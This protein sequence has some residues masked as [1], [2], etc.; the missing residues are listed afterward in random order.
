ML[1]LAVAPLC[2]ECPIPT[3]PVSVCLQV[4]AATAIGEQP[5][6]CLLDPEA[7]ARLSVAEAVTNLVFAPV[8]SLRVGRSCQQPQGTLTL[9]SAV[10]GSSSLRGTSPVLVFTAPL[11]WVALGTSLSSQPSS[12]FLFTDFRRGVTRI[13]MRVGRGCAMPQ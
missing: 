10:S 3:W 2:P 5:I 11:K 9:P 1:P 4:G 6:K 13:P 12:V 8:T 7:G